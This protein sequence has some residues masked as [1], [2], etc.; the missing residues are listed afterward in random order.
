MNDTAPSNRSAE[1]R[2]IRSFVVRAGRITPAQERA[3][4][5]LW[6]RFGIPFDAAAARL[7]LDAWFGRSAPRVL[8]IGF[9]NAENLIALAAAH[10][11]RDYLGIEVHRPGVGRLLL[12]AAARNLT[13]LRAICHDAVEVLERGIAP[14][15][16]DE[17]LILF[18]DPWHKARHHKRRLIQ[19]PLAALLAARLKPGGILRLATDWQPYAQQM[20]ELLGQCALLQN[21]YPVQ[22]FAPRPAQRAPTRFEQ[23]GTRLGHGVWDLEFRRR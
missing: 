7:D 17:I 2:R 3:L 20:L 1:P 5:E 12:A 11:Y 9:G 22:G 6:P 10:P 19:S 21:L 4:D 23:R 14:Q 13:N 8:E 18:P 16:L 15:S